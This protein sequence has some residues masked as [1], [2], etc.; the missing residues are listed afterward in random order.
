[1]KQYGTVLPFSR[2]V[3]SEEQHVRA[4]SQLFTNYGLSV[5]ANPGLT[6]P[7]AFSSLTA[8][9]QAGVDAEI[10]D[11]ALYD[12][13]LRVTGNPDVVRVYKNLQAASLNW[14]LPAFEACN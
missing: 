4:L 11:A 14:H 8:A 10:A 9:C 1:M 13:L 7:P 3:R 5:P 12:D 6:P 2:I